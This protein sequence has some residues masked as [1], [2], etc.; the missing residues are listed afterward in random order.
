LWIIAVGK[1]LWDVIEIAS[2]S[3]PRELSG[4][5]GV[6]VSSWVPI[7]ASSKRKTILPSRHMQ[8]AEKV[9][10]QACTAWKSNEKLSGAIPTLKIKRK[11]G[12]YDDTGD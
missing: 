8:P 11:K 10:Y 7:I 5:L 12:G 2:Y 9:T 3:Y 1:I 6:A 4:C